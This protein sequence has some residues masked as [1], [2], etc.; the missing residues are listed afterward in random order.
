VHAYM[1][2]VKIATNCIF[3]DCTQLVSTINILHHVSED[4]VRPVFYFG[5]LRPQTLGVDH[6][7]GAVPKT[8][9]GDGCARGWGWFEDRDVRGL[10]PRTRL[11][12]INVRGSGSREGAIQ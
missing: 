10:I 6:T 3:Y 2:S 8:R 4:R 5:G 12:Y 11:Q 7:I 9:L 1:V